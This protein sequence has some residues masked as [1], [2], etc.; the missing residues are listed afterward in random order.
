MSLTT[1]SSIISKIRLMVQIDY[2]ILMG[3]HKCY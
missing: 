2:H 3:D 1:Y